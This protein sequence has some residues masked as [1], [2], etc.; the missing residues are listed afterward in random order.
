[1]Y[2]RQDWCGLVGWYKSFSIFFHALRAGEYGE[3]CGTCEFNTELQGD[4]VVPVC[5]MAYWDHNVDFT[6]SGTGGKSSA[7]GLKLCWGEAENL[8]LPFAA[9][10]VHNGVI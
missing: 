3:A 8:P 7:N 2:H 5:Q 4:A 10:S 9:R 6:A 1:M